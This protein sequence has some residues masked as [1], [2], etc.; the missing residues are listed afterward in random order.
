MTSM[1]ERR[2]WIMV[3]DV[4]A[5]CTERLSMITPPVAGAGD[6]SATACLYRHLRTW[7]RHRTSGPWPACHGLPPASARQLLQLR[8]LSA[9]DFALLPTRLDRKSFV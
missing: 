9:Y 8:I 5:C 7:F 2:A 1:A 3:M 4:V 6:A